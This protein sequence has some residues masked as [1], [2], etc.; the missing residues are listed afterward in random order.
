MN[1]GPDICLH[2]LI[3]ETGG[4]GCLCFGR[5]SIRAGDDYEEAAKNG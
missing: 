2:V 1:G 4:S 3:D 5:A